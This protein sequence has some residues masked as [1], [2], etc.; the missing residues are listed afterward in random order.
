MSKFNHYTKHKS[1]KIKDSTKNQII[2]LSQNQSII[3]PHI[4]P[5]SLFCPSSVC[6]LSLSCSIH[7][8]K[9]K[10]IANKPHKKRSFLRYNCPVSAFLL[11][12]YLYQSIIH[13]TITYNTIVPLYRVQSCDC[14]TMYSCDCINPSFI[15]FMHCMPFCSCRSPS[16]LYLS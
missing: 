16:I 1:T 11:P 15:Y 2:K 7:T 8:K 9:H 4:L 6:S 12:Y 5:I 3:N 14:I 10:T 13:C